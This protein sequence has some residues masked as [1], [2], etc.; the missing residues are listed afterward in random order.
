MQA[1]VLIHLRLG[2]AFSLGI[3]R[4]TSGDYH[5]PPGSCTGYE[6]RYVGSA[7]LSPYILAPRPYSVLDTQHSALGALQSFIKYTEGEY[8]FLYTNGYTA[9]SFLA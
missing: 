4:R 1:E 5:N 6:S 7:L 2:L 3:T 8:N 9:A